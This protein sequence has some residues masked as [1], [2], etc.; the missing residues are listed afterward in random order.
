MKL[1]SFALYLG[2]KSSQ[3]MDVTRE[4]LERLP[5]VFPA[6]CT[7]IESCEWLIPGKSDPNYKMI[8]FK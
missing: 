3:D 1:D 2:R 6:L 7:K 4:N 5:A 8:I